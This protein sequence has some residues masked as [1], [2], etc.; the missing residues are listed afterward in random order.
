MR[1]LNAAEDPRWQ[2]ALDEAARDY[3]DR[4]ITVEQISSRIADLAL[5]LAEVGRQPVHTTT[6]EARLV[7]TLI[8]ARQSRAKFF[9]GDMFAEPAWDMLLDLT[10]AKIENKY[11]SVSSLCIAAGVPSTTALRYIRS[12]QQ[13]GIIERHCDPDDARR[14]F[15]VISNTTFNAMIEFFTYA[16]ESLLAAA[17]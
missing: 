7:R 8:A 6:I 11:V 3:H 10:A 1:R 2:P 5:K 4:E 14:S 9:G 15:L 16:R 13:A 17:S 12:M